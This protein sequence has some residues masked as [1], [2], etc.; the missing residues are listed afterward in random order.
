MARDPLH[1]ARGRGP[2]SREA[3]E[4][5]L[6]EPLGEVSLYRSCGDLDLDRESSSRGWCEC[7][8]L[9]RRE[10]SRCELSRRESRERGGDWLRAEPAG[11]MAALVIAT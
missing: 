7:L 5:L 6:E 2:E 10:L 3:Y 4:L 1:G 11:L 9:S 8:E